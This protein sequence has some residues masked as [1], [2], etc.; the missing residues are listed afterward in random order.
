MN[1][2]KL[3]EVCSVRRKEVISIACLLAG[4]V[5]AYTIC[6]MKHK[7]AYIVTDL[8]VGDLGKLG[9][10]L[11]QHGHNASERVVRWSITTTKK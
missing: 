2:S 3:K 1:K 7:G 10:T 11:I 5:V 9:E 8:S 4:A 6:G